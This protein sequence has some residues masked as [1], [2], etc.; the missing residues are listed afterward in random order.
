VD[1][2]RYPLRSAPEHDGSVVFLGRILPHKGVHFLVRGLPEGTTLH[3]VGME[4]D[5]IY[6]E[7]LLRLAAGKPI[8]F[9]PG[10]AD[11][12]IR[13]LLGRCMALVHPTPVDERGSA[14]C[15]EL[16]GL[17]LVEA[18]ARGCPVVAS[19]VGPLPEIVED[20]RTGLLVPPNS[21]EAITAALE[22]LA[23]D[24]EHWRKLSAAA[25]RRVE[26]E[27]TWDRVAERCL[28]AY[29]DF[30]DAAVSRPLS[31]Y[32]QASPRPARVL[33]VAHA[34][35]GAETGAGQ[36]AHELARALQ[37]RGYDAQA[38]S[39][40]PLDERVRWWSIWRAQRHRLE[41][42]LATAG[43]FD[44]I[45]LPASSISRR[46]AAAALVVARS[47]QPEI[48]YFARSFREELGR[49]PRS[50]LR[51]AGYPLA[52]PGYAGIY[53]GWRRADAILCLGSRELLWMR[54]TFPSLRD[55]L[56]SYVIAPPATDREPL[57]KIRASRALHRPSNGLRFLWLGRWS[58]HK[59]T[60][61]LV[62]FVRRRAASHEDDTFTVA[63][64]GPLA[65]RDFPESL[66]AAGR[67]RIVP[68]YRRT[69]LL[70]LLREHDVGLFTSDVEG[71]GIS[72]QEM[73][74]AGL[75][76]YATGAGAVADLKPYFPRSLRP[77][78]PPDT[79]PRPESPLDPEPTY[80]ELFMWDAIAAR[81][82]REV[83]APLLNRR[84]AESP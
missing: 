26:E 48:Q 9:H 72:L 77:F 27:F 81:Y 75:P 65:A 44:V 70:R 31:R 7:E 54:R 40:E 76:V 74:E 66:L 47:V 23:A 45:D 46:I 35:I 20:G 32:P 50:F 15:N 52:A 22:H 49:L 36:T 58:P 8:H 62:D 57:A 33:V 42:F 19:D 67:V 71:W 63:G 51:I 2:E 4:A 39:T 21:P 28:A 37:R 79:I 18:M 1:L 14:G 11:A 3:V 12:E 34:P 55:R 56:N 24:E 16:F 13:E 69:E 53:R 10:L 78:P 61:R 41:R 29:R 17:V 59:G 25:R 84:D 43:P 6:R 83:L 64:C 38:W 73:L 80:H 68:T 82:D 5:P 60:R 30:G